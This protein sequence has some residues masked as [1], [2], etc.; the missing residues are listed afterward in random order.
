MAKLVLCSVGHNNLLATMPDADAERLMPHLV[1]VDLPRTTILERA[2]ETIETVYFPTDGVGSMI[3]S[4]RDDRQIEAGLFG[5][6][7]MSG[8]SIVMGDDQPANRTLMQVGGSALALPAA[9]LQ[10]I[11][12]DA[13]S[14]QRHLLRYAQTMMTQTAQTALSN[15]QARLEER[16]ARW[17]LMCHDRV[18][19]NEMELTH[20]FLS[21]MLGVRRAGVT[22]GTH[23]LEGKGMIRAERARITILDR[24]GLEEEAHQSYGVPEREYARLIGTREAVQ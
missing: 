1:A 21:V 11:L 3:A 6:D 17:L 19:G 18:K 9:M 12:G 13:P 23:M 14:V 8:I 7:G 2:F 24:D 20:E 15:G 5:R 10:K 16:L 4:G 22:V